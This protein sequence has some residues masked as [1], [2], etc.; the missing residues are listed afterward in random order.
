MVNQDGARV[1]VRVRVRLFIPL[2]AHP[3]LCSPRNFILGSAITLDIYTYINTY[4]HTILPLICAASWRYILIHS[5][6]RDSLG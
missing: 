2:S 4:I 5:F 1:R 6:C 3:F